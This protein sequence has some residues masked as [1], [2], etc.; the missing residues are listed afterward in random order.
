[1][2]VLRKLKVLCGFRKKAWVPNP[3]QHRDVFTQRF[4]VMSFAVK[5]T[6]EQVLPLKLFVIRMSMCQMHSAL[7]N[8]A[9]RLHSVILSQQALF[10]GRVATP[11]QVS[12][13]QIDRW[14]YG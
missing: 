1:M 5:R 4:V 12:P 6:S 14:K 9:K 8:R 3:E 13:S 7:T 10:Y 11:L 2:H